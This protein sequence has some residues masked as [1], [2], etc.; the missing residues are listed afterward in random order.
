[1]NVT[2]V[3]GAV[4]LGY[5]AHRSRQKG[6]LAMHSSVSLNLPKKAIW[7]STVLLSEPEGSWRRIR[8][9]C[10]S[11]AVVVPITTRPVPPDTDPSSLPVRRAET[12][13]RSFLG[14]TKSDRQVGKRINTK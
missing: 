7:C 9:N 13:H 12:A 5:A 1:M 2:V 8:T 4:V 14:C 10:G 11:S 6:K 3:K